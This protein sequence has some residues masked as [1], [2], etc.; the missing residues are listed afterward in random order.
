MNRVVITGAAGFVGSALVKECLKNGL[1]VYAI[2]VVEDPSFR[3]P[4]DNSNLIYIKK[5]LNDFKK[6]ETDLS[7]KSIDTFYHFAWN[8]SAGPLREDYICQVDN[9]LLAVELMKF[10]KSIG[11]SKFVFAGTIMEFEANGVIYSQETKPQMAYLY[12]VGKSLAH[13]LCK[14]IANRIGID[15]VWGYITNTFGVGESS[16][17]LINSTIRK[18]IKHEELNF[19]SGTQN[20]DFVYIDDVVRAFY[21]LGEKGKAN[22]GYLIGSGQARQ[23][24]DFLVDL[25]NICDKDAVPNFGVIPSSGGSLKLES[26]SIEDL[27]KDCGFEPTV[28]F[29]EGIRKTLDWIKKEDFK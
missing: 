8:G 1:F 27:K 2:D 3:L 26:F 12:G 14:P 7:N 20:Y 19:T 25:V 22:K 29:E 10:A 13:Q 4:L 16:P 9:A 18:C 24:R 11:C 15:L 17:R 6:L 21:L 28:S 5:D 23:L